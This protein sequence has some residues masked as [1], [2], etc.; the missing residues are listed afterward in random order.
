MQPSQE[1]LHQHARQLF[2][3]NLLEDALKT[4]NQLCAS[5]PDDVQA[6]HMGSAILGILGRYDEAIVSCKKV[7]SLSPKAHE[8]YLNLANIHMACNRFTEAKSNFNKALKRKPNDAQ[9]LT[10]LGGLYIKLNQI[11]K[12]IHCLQKAL[13]NNPG[14]YETLNNLGVAY[15]LKN[16]LDKAEECFTTVIRK[17]PEF[18]DAYINLAGVYTHQQLYDKSEALYKTALQLD[19]K[20][21]D[22]LCNMGKLFQT[23]G[24]FDSARK[25]Y[26]KTLLSHPES[27]EALS[28]LASLSERQGNNAEALDM[29]TPIILSGQ[30]DTDALITYSTLCRKANRHTEA[31]HLLETYLE[32]HIALNDKINL[33][34]ALGELHEDLLAYEKA[35]KCF[36]EGNNLDKQKTAIDCGKKYFQSIIDCINTETLP[37]ISKSDNTSDMPIFI[38][39]MPRSGTSLVE[40][41][42]GS[43]PGVMAGDERDDISDII[44]NI[45]NTYPN[46][47]Q[48]PNLLKTIDKT[49][50]NEISSDHIQ[51]IEGIANG[52]ARFTDKTPLHGIHLGFINQ[53]FP[54]SRVIICHRNPID[55]CLSIYFHRFNNTHAYA[56]DLSTL[57][58]FYCNYSKLLKHWIALLDLQ[59]HEVQYEDLV[60]NPEQSTR[61]LIKFC[62]LGWDEKC[63][64]FHTNKRTVNTPSYDQVRKP[65]YTSSISRW[66]HYISQLDPLIASLELYCKDL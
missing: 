54:S 46:L 41:I 13:R 24:E 3:N 32:K 35:F 51:L 27:T 26:Q 66:K 38:V 56:K 16:A 49:Q 15:R 57:G 65:I 17:Q 43:H 28:A 59:I 4:Y 53:L 52:K 23:T 30:Y 31:I 19:P 10:N 6:W 22:T 11:D 61:E 40:Q 20:N 1:N 45:K 55:T 42:L 33:L 14:N 44:D 12:A 5:H 39:G 50:L 8:P 62:G 37:Q 9:V 7:I 29:L 58:Q 21:K 47:P 64:S 34:F 36:H 25:C 60:R 2:E 48:Y 18:I 63:L